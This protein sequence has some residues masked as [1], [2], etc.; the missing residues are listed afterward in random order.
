MK[1]FIDLLILSG[2]DGTINSN[3]KIYNFF[4]LSEK[5]SDLLEFCLP[6]GG[7]PNI[8]Y[9]NM[10]SDN[11]IISYLFAID[12]AIDRDSL[13]SLCFIIHNNVI[14]EDFKKII[15]ELVNQLNQSS[16]LN[17]ED[18]S[19]NLGKIAEGLDNETKI[20]IEKMKFDVSKY[21]KKNKLELIKKNVK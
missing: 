19:S 11:I 18:L 20:V 10:Y 2:L 12:N 9:Q 16:L 4:P 5:K 8:F 14:L 21:I 13:A 1:N 3:P 6:I 15:L 7:K 17:F